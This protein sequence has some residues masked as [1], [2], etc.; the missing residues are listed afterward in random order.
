MGRYIHDDKYDINLLYPDILLITNLNIDKSSNPYLCTLS[1]QFICDEQDLINIPSSKPAVLSNP[2]F[3]F[4]KPLNESQIISFRFVKTDILNATISIS[5]KKEYLDTFLT[6]LKNESAFFSPEYKGEI[7]GVNI[8]TEIARFE[9]LQNQIQDFNFKEID[10]FDSIEFIKGLI[11]IK[12]SDNEMRK[13]ILKNLVN[14]HGSF[15]KISIKGKKQWV[16]RLEEIEKIIS[17]FAQ[18]M[19]KN[20]AINATSKDIKIKM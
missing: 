7:E 4:K 1:V 10:F 5:F 11:Q 3:T 18:I 13:N 20:E 19:Q 15:S 6:K 12:I 17:S 14:E 9:L 16:L 2:F 8:N